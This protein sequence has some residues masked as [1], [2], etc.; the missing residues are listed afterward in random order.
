MTGLLENIKSNGLIRQTTQRLTPSRTEATQMKLF[1]QRT[2]LKLA[3]I[4]CLG[5]FSSLFLNSASFASEAKQPSSQDYNLSMAGA[6]INNWCKRNLQTSEH[7]SIHAC[8][9]QLSQRYN[10]DVSSLHFE[11]CTVAAVGDIVKIADCMDTRF[12]AW[13]VQEQNE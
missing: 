10:L 7:I 2:P 8:N 5:L 1:L 9:Y 12:N 4:L 6:L 3:L 11:E 13:Q